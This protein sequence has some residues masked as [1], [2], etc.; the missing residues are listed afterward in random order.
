MK[1]LFLL[2][3]WPLCGVALAAVGLATAHLLGHW[4]VIPVMVLLP[5]AAVGMALLLT[6][7]VPIELPGVVA[8]FT[9]VY[10]VAAV[11]AGLVMAYLVGRPYLDLTA[12][13]PA[14]NLRVSD[15]PDYATPGFRHFGNGRIL[16]D[17]RG[18]YIESGVDSEG[19]YYQHL[20]EVAPV[21]EIGWRADDPITLW[22][23]TG[24]QEA[25]V[26]DFATWDRP[27]QG[28]VKT[29]HTGDYWRAI[30]TAVAE[31]N[32]LAAP[33]GLLLRLY[34][35]DYVQLQASFQ[36]TMRLFLLLVAAAGGVPLAV[37]LVAQIA[38][39]PTYR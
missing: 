30:E 1:L 6:L 8:G 38:R 23:V 34:A 13:S 29:S 12:F 28:M 33:D 39:P 5:V 14:Q 32:L 16:A 7:H 36:A 18:R 17:R 19:L 10:F 26:T 21:V 27:I 31:H 2:V 25:V 22:V 35:Q 9:Y 11:M 37:F 20:Y 4:L 15:A 3:L 24:S